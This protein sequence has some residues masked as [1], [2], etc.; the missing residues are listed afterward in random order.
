MMRPQAV[1][2]SSGAASAPNTQSTT[3]PPAAGRSGRQCKTHRKAEP[4][5]SWLRSERREV[6]NI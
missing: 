6:D 2:S 5:A 1:I 4:K 3:V